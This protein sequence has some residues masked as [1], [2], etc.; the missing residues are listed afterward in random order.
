MSKFGFLTNLK[1]EFSKN[2][3]SLARTKGLDEFNS[4]LVRELI[5]VLAKREPGYLKQA[6]RIL[7]PPESFVDSFG[8]CP[9]RISAACP[10]AASGSA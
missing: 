4:N 7:F 1:L 5:E 3:S 8:T 6:K 10:W 2:C 9:C